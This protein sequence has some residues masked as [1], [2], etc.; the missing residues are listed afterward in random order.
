M[1]ET[2]LIVDDE[3][4][5]RKLVAH[6]LDHAG[7]EILEAGSAIEALREVEKTRPDL[8]ILDVSM[9]QTNG[10]QLA[11]MLRESPELKRVPIMFLTARKELEDKL[12]AFNLGAADYLNKPFEGEELVA[13]VSALLRDKRE[14]RE[15]EQNARI[16][17]LSQ[18]MITLAHYI[19]NSLMTMMGR[20]QITTCESPEDVEKL[21]KSVL[22]G[23]ERIRAVVS[24]LREMADRKELATTEYVGIEKAMFDIQN[25]LEKRMDE[26][27]REIEAKF[28]NQES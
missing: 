17:T 1:P 9:P 2:I 12:L 27:E 28:P 5:L 16:E 22:R 20:A 8:M 11:A 26:V 4:H 18:M 13:R 10:F 21:K 14:A 19:N 6:F 3:A 15:E 24:Q 7:Y 23:G 25:D